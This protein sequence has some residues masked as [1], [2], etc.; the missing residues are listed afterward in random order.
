MD[1]A[2]K[3][4][5]EKA[6][7]KVGRNQQILG[8]LRAGWS[9]KKIAEEYGLSYSWAK[10]LCKRLKNGNNGERKSGSVRPRKT[11]AREDRLLLREAVIWQGH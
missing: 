11:T 10:K 8:S 4:R 2:R 6:R 9:A 7:K 1:T 3:R 5:L